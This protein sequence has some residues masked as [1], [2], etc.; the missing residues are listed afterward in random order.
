M[1]KKGQKMSEIM[2]DAKGEG[3]VMENRKHGQKKAR[4]GGGLR[5]CPMRS[6]RES[7]LT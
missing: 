3:D 4:L 1:N 7:T 5:E 6:G 2:T